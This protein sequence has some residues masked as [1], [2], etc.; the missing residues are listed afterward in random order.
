MCIRDSYPHNANRRRMALACERSLGRLR[1]DRID[2]Y[3]L[4]WRSGPTPL[5]EIV[6]G[7]EQLRGEGKIVRWGVS[8]FDV[9]DLEELARSD[10]AVNQVLYNPEHRGIEHDLLPWCAQR[11][12]PIMAYSP[13]GQGGRLL[14]SPVLEQIGRRHAATAAQVAL[15]WV[16]RD[17]KVLAIP[18]ATDLA[19]LRSNVAAL[20]LQ[21]KAEDLAEI[22][23]AFAPPRRKRSLD[24][25]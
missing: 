21:L 8:N 7:F 24:M 3:L 12:L 4:H 10:C 20:E 15:A 17:G 18:K 9:D 1:T 14:S 11:R 2:L 13:L 6:E 5:H 16:L 23:A 19:H 25:L 22:D